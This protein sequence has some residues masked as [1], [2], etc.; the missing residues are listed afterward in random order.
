LR[1]VAD[2]LGS[3]EANGEDAKGD[4]QMIRGWISAHGS[5]SHSLSLT[6]RKEAVNMFK[7]NAQARPADEL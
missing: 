6:A 5:I 1:S 4:Q 3:R 7:V 2:F